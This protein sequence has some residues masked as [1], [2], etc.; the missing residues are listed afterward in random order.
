MATANRVMAVVI[1]AQTAV[2]VAMAV[3]AINRPFDLP[4][5]AV[6]DSAG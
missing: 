1:Q 3:A 4:E 6:H 2:V 5:T